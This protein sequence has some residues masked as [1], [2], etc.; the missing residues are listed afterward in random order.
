LVGICLLD[1]HP[2]YSQQGSGRASHLMDVEG[3]GTRL[4]ATDRKA[5]TK[6]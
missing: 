4:L 6:A 5:E 3:R 2:G 1:I